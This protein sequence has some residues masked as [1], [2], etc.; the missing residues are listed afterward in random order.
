MIEKVIYVLSNNFNYDDLI[1]CDA[2]YGYA[3]SLGLE[4][5]LL[6]NL[7]INVNQA[8]FIDNRL[9]ESELGILT[10]YILENPDVLFILKIV[11]PCEHHKH[12]YYYKFL[13]SSIQFNN[14]FYVSVYSFAGLTKELADIVKNRIEFLPFPYLKEK[15]IIH[16]KCTDRINKIIVSGVVEKFI[17]PERY[18]F[19]EWMKIP[20]IRKIIARLEHPGYKDLNSTLI[21]SNV[22]D[23]Y[24][25]FL[26]GYKYMFVSPSKYKLELLKFYECAY[27]GCIPIGVIPYSWC[28]IPILKSNFIQLSLSRRLFFYPSLILALFKV[29][30]LTPSIKEVRSELHKTRNPK[31]LYSNLI[32]IV[33][34]FR[35]N[36][37]T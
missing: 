36:L 32:L 19:V 12:H 5:S 2:G 22:G 28:H 37:D 17:Y 33:N 20:I 15:E 7:S 6:G 29:I 30:F 31:L 16:Y 4:T 34:K 11:D 23:K 10:K 18:R 8:Y 25:K 1:C 13:F 3:E 9:L 14:I 27:A 24:V 26:S 35:E 21:H